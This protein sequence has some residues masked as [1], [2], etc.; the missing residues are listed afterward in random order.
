MKRKKK[1]LIK[2]IT[3]LI[4]ALAMIIPLIFST[5]VNAA[6]KY[7]ET[8]DV[9][10]EECVAISELM[11]EK[12]Y[13]VSRTDDETFGPGLNIIVDDKVLNIYENYPQYYLNGEMIAA[14]TELVKDNSTGIS[15]NFPVSQLPTRTNAI[16]TTSENQNDYDFFVPTQFI[17]EYLGIDL[18]TEKGYMFEIP[19]ETTQESETSQNVT[20]E[21]NE[22]TES[23][24]EEETTEKIYT[25]IPSEGS[26][27][28]SEDETEFRTSTF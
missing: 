27:T 7:I 5:T 3:C 13:I 22:S 2:R 4:L 8:K 1:L 18:P 9:E 12:D 15:Y 26:E 20:D 11:N 10:G 21:T 23:E 19:D 24:I 17:Y 25:V 16:E 6:E 28:E 14:T